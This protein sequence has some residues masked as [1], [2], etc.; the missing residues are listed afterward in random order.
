MSEEDDRF[1]ARLDVAKTNPWMIAL[2]GAPVALGVALTIAF[3]LTH[4]AM[5]AF[6][7]PLI[8]C[9]FGLLFF[10]W[11]NKPSAVREYAHVEAT[12]ATLSVGG[13]RFPRHRIRR[14]MLLPGR[15]GTRPNV[16]VEI[17]N[18]PV[19]Q[20]G[21]S[22][23]HEGRAL[24]RAMGFDA[25]QVVVRFRAP[26]SAAAEH[27]LTAKL[28]QQAGPVLAVMLALGARVFVGHASFLL[29]A[30]LAIALLPQLL[31]SS[32]EVGADG[33]LVR[34]LW[35]KRFIR[36]IDISRVGSFE[37]VRG[38][39]R[40]FGARLVLASGANVDIPV[41]GMNEEAE[42]LA[43]R[44]REAAST[45]AH[46]DAAAA[47][48][49]DRG[50]LAVGDW[51]RRLK[52]LGA[53]ATATLRSAAIDA[54]RLWELLESPSAPAKERAAA[55]VALSTTDEVGAKARIRV[56][57]SAVAEP[58]L[59]VAIEAASDDDEAALED[60][61]SLLEEKT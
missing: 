53:G 4:T 47:A 60:A 12:H 46:G 5:F 1:V 61:L 6:A 30:L 56:A 29:I 14:A 44:I 11:T 7:P 10:N 27:W 58:R 40:R 34:W 49:L 21:V 52:G 28:L 20:L 18:R 39:K 19:M 15:L 42:L 32:V 36:A 2:A 38:G 17:K 26:P 59:R 57:A 9:G 43:E 45:G 16:R 3:A 48:L 23:E 13:K 31:P 35:M 25:S 54:D 22:D 33:V 37:E 55:A 41:R 8:L 24:L 51:V 50:G